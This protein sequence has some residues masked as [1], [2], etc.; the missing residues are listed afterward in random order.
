MTWRPMLAAVVVAGA[1]AACQPAPSGLTCDSSLPRDVCGLA[2]EE[3]SRLYEE[4]G[5]VV[6]AA[7]VRPTQ[8]RKCLHGD[9][10]LADVQTWLQGRSDSV[11]AT[12]GLHA[13]TAEPTICLPL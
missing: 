8:V 12:V 2:F 13:I 4:G 9:V 3:A 7:V 11:D 10:P 6:V 5:M 1:M